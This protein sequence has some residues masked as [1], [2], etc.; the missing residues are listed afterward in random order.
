MARPAEPA[1]PTATDETADGAPA[2]KSKKKLF[3][4]LGLIV[5]LGGG[6]AGAWFF[7]QGHGASEE[8]TDEAP[9]VPVFLAL[10]TF[11]VNL[12][13]GEQYLQT[14]VTL[15]VADQSQVDA[16]KQHM[17]RVRSRL[18]TL[19]SSKHADELATAEDKKKLAQEIREQIKQ[20]FDPK[21]QPQQVDDVLFTSF[22]IQ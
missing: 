6:G 12:Q 17:P 20:P 11:T 7:T 4:I 15:Q 10:E 8:A 18:L 2:R 21:G 1:E 3:V 14:D 22:V 13:D 5:L 19:L 16:I 9:K